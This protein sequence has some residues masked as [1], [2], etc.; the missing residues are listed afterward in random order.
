MDISDFET[1]LNEETTVLY[2]AQSGEEGFV[3]LDGN[4]VYIIQKTKTEDDFK[5][6]EFLLENVK[7]ITI[8][9]PDSINKSRYSHDETLSEE[10]R[11]PENL[12]K[13]KFD[14]PNFQESFV[15]QASPQEATLELLRKS[16]HV[17][18]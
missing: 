15:I 8:K 13:I 3:A 11:I 5:L 14:F 7:E 18:D 16:P 10:Q 6:T 1:A 17:E 9:K 12:S 4:V 2:L